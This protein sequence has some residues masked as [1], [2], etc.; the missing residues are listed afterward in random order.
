MSVNTSSRIRSVAALSA[1]LGICIALP[2][3]AQSVTTV[4]V[5]AVTL[6]ALAN[7]DSYFSIPL[8]RPSIFEGVVSAKSGT[9]LS[10]SGASFGTNE[11]QYAAGIQSNTYYIQIASGAASGQF[12]TILSNTANAVATEYESD[13]LGSVQVG[14]RVVIRPY[15]TLGTLFPAS[16]AGASFVASTSNFTAGRR[17]EILFPDVTTVGVNKSPAS[18]Y[19]F[20][21]YWR[22]SGSVSENKN[23]TII[24]PDTYIIIRGNN[25]A[26][27]TKLVIS[28]AV[29]PGPQ[30]VSLL[31]SSSTRNDNP[32]GGVLPIDTP[33]E[34]LNLVEEG[35]F[36]VSTSN[37][38]AGRGDEL[39]LF[40][41]AIAAKNK[42]PSTVYFYNS[43][44]RKSGS[45]ATNQNTTL[46]PAGSAYVIRKKQTLSNETT[47]W[48]QPPAVVAN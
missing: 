46:I 25:Y 44:W 40:D 27:S 30:V 13:I 5:G 11:L 42:A 34:D 8:V 38:T 1:L 31:S 23:D 6:E 4:P 18:L 39:L 20:N 15:W 41:N 16:S 17:T 3:S 26:T 22:K 37:F 35:A 21:S 14:D 10:L 9:T 28:G 36:I 24:P 7:S 12:S 33:L 29:Q 32:A 48:K 43:Y 45:V 2:A 19:F 47:D